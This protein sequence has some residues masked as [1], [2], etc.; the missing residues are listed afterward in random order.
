MFLVSC[1]LPFISVK[2][3]CS[4]LHYSFS[5]KN[6]IIKNKS[7]YDSCFKRR[8]TSKQLCLEDTKKLKLTFYCS[9]RCYYSKR[10]VI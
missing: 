1:K 7:M 5:S 4:V 2:L 3:K 10:F 9:Q 6:Y 8:K